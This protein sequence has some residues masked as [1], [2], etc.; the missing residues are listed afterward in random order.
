[1]SDRQ[2]IKDLS[3]SKL[4]ELLA[5]WGVE[6]YRF[7][8]IIKW[9]YQK[10]ISQFEEMSNLAKVLRDQLNEHFYI[11]KWQPHLEQKSSDGTRK[12]LFKLKDGNTIESV[13]IPKDDRN[14]LCISTQVGCAMGCSFCLTST[15]GL[16]RNLS[17][18][19]I[20]EQVAAV[21]RTIA[22]EKITNIVYMGMGEPFHNYDNVLAS[23]QILNDHNAFVIGKRRITVSTS[24]L[25]PQ[26]KQFAKDSD[27]K[28]AVSLTATT[29][30]IRDHVIPVNKKY[31]IQELLQACQ[32][33]SKITGHA[34]TFEY[35]LLENVNDS[36]EDAKRLAKLLKNIPAKVNLI[37]FN[38]FPESSFKR[39]S[40]ERMFAMQDVLYHAGIQTN[41]RFSRGTDILG[42]CG[43]LK[44]AQEPKPANIE[45]QA[46]ASQSLAQ[47]QPVLS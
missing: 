13:L 15:L 6:G 42:A 8:Q 20:T 26:I 27:V 28:L 36:L 46:R 19:E 3:F 10:D 17:L 21:A 33:Y 24:G 31:P 29:N 43:Q 16:M 35:T 7:I 40:D 9:L 2:N 12:F 32:E 14:T 18:F 47:A 4:Q 22:P 37:P 1:M 38:E 39:S 30:E 5:T 34:V 41:I 44:A 25:V 45:R 11:E 23:L